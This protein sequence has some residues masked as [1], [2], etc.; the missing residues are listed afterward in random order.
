ME[1]TWEQIDPRNRD[2]EAR[3]ELTDRLP[4]VLS[5]EFSLNEIKLLWAAGPDSRAP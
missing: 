5:R 1:M 3:V 2:I 4:R